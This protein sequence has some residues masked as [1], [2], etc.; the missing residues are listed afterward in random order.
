[1]EDL[2]K[3][4]CVRQYFEAFRT[5]DRELIESLLHPE[6]QFMS[7]I[8]DPM[9]ISSFF[10]RCWPLSEST[11]DVHILNMASDGELVFCRYDMHMSGDRH[12]CNVDTFLVKE[13]KIFGQQAYFGDPPDGMS[14]TEF[15]V[16]S[17]D[18]KQAS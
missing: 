9:N 6:F 15:D 5:Q 3:Q 18:E 8:D 1:M 13:G 2:D 10:S 4:N 12:F 14:R 17:R 11:E 7:P 16:L